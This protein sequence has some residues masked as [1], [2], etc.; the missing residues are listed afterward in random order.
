MRSRQSDGRVTAPPPTEIVRKAASGPR[1]QPPLASQSRT[2]Q[3]HQAR[4]SPS[5]SAMAKASGPC[6]KGRST[7]STASI[8][9]AGVN[10]QRQAMSRQP[11][12]GRSPGVTSLIAIVRPPITSRVS[13]AQ[14]PDPSL[15]RKACAPGY[16]PMTASRAVMQPPSSRV[17]K[18]SIPALSARSPLEAEHSPRA[19]ACL[20][21]PATPGVEGPTRPSIRPAPT[22]RHIRKTPKRVSSTGAFSAA[23]SDSPSTSRDLRGSMIPSSQSRAEA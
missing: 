22:A 19:T 10:S 3:S 17:H 9:T 16:R 8:T 11:D 7:T 4:T 21:Q 1:D 15:K 13:S 18:Y 14:K 20:P 6:W 23:L 2:W 5:S 12:L